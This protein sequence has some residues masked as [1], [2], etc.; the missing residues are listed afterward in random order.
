M[1]T[2]Q[3]DYIIHWLI[4]SM[5]FQCIG[6]CNGFPISSLRE[7]KGM[8][9]NGNPFI[10]PLN[11][12]MFRCLN[13]WM[14]HWKFLDSL[15]QWMIQIK[16]II[17]SMIKYQISKCIKLCHC[18]FLYTP[19][20]LSFYILHHIINSVSSITKNISNWIYNQKFIWIG[21]NWFEQ[22]YVII[23]WIDLFFLHV[24]FISWVV[25]FL[26][27]NIFLFCQYTHSINPYEKYHIR[28]NSI[29]K[30]IKIHILKQF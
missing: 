10:D 24:S 4:H 6:W 22:I 28:N 19:S 14:S 18:Y 20:S 11:D 9:S 1:Y 2:V 29:F 17:N 16:W 8:Q 27:F 23:N 15:T 30:H 3:C 7:S 5:D 26:R 25:F 12:L 13:V 21:L